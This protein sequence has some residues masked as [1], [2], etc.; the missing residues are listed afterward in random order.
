MADGAAFP[1]EGEGGITGLVLIGR[2]EMRFSP[3]PPTEQGQLRIFSGSEVMV[4]PFD[5]AFVRMNPFDYKR[6]TTGELLP[7]RVDPRL[8][9]RAQEI[10]TRDGPKSFSLDLQDLSRDTWY[11]LPPVGDFL[12]EVQTRRWGQLTFARTGTQAEDITLFSRARRRTI[13]LYPSSAKLALRGRFYTDEELMEYDVL[14][15]NIEAQVVPERQFI[16]GRARLLLRVRAGGTNSLT[17]RLAETLAVTN[18]MSLELRALAA[19][20]RPQPEQHRHQSSDNAG[21]RL[22]SHADHLRIRGAWHRRTSTARRCA[23]PRF[24]RKTLR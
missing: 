1:V 22:R 19:P 2:G 5:T 15:Y 3:S 8:L 11:L 24:R 17:L 14:D 7:T 10:F 23:S 13:A 12:A 16:Q 4:A 6:V 20:A 9:R 18:I 21:T